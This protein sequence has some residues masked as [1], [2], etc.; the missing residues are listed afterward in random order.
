MALAFEPL[1]NRVVEW[2]WSG[3]SDAGTVGQ[4]E[5][6]GPSTLKAAA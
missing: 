4:A 5:R 2:C 1:T 6:S 3:G